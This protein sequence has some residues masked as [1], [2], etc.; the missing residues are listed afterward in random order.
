MWTSY[1]LRECV[2]KDFKE[3]WWHRTA[4]TYTNG[5]ENLLGKSKV[6]WH[7]HCLL[8]N[9]FWFCNWTFSL[10]FFLTFHTFYCTLSRANLTD[11]TERRLG[12]AFI[13]VTGAVKLKLG[14]ASQLLCCLI[15]LQSQQQLQICVNL[16]SPQVA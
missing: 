9:Y 4:V 13:S 16:H 3:V 5:E 14:L 11:E 2:Q 8:E 12:T 10:H 6:V 7:R 1:K 15:H